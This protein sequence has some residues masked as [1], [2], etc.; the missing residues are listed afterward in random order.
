[1]I[2]ADN[3]NPLSERFLKAMD[4]LGVTG[5]KLAKQKI[6]PA[7]STLTAIK[8]GY[9]KPSRNTIEAFLEAYPNINRTWLL[10]GEGKMTNQNVVKTDSGSHIFVKDYKE[11]VDP[12]PIYEIQVSA[13]LNS[14]FAGSNPEYLAGMVLFPKMPRAEGGMFVVGDSMYPLLKAGDIIG[15]VSLHDLESV[16]YGEIYVL[17][18]EKAGDISIVVK[19]IQPSEKEGHYKLVSYNKEH[20]TME[21]HKSCITS[22]ARV[23]FSIR[24]FAPM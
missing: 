4:V 21:V 19:Y 24:K 18:I 3:L 2:K 8:R 13:G 17:Q 16:I 23:T 11:Q 10:K 22:I 9:Q 12:V 5:Y 14:I 6:L 7:D 15:C 20:A 1:M